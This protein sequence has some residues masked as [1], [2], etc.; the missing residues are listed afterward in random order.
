MPFF[1]ARPSAVFGVRSKRGILP[2]LTRQ[3]I[4]T[5]YVAA[6]Y[7]DSSP[8]R[9][10]NSFDMSTDTCT[11]R[12]DLLQTAS[13]Y[14][15]GMHGRNN[16]FILGADGMGD[17]TTV[18]SFN[19]RNNTTYTKPAGLVLNWAVGSSGTVMSQNDDGDYLK[20][21]NWTGAGGTTQ[22]HTFN[23]V[24]EATTTALNT[25]WGGAGTS[26][27]L[28]DELYGYIWDE[29]NARTL[30]IQYATDGLT[31]A[32]WVA[33]FHGQQKGLSAKTGRGYAGNEGTYNGGNN[34]RISNFAT[35]T[36]IGTVAKPIQDSG[37]ENYVTGQD[38]GY[39]LGMYGAPGPT[40]NNRSFRFNYSTQS[41]SE[42]GASGQP[43]GGIAAAGRSSGIGMWRD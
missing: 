36:N 41:G 8:W 38:R 3:I 5:G 1:S 27:Q 40:Q 9:N 24:T 31:N 34:F 26:N 12:G 11:N 4:T 32:A 30:K 37:E 22:L 39:M 23:L 43:S 14:S 20:A 13:A 19:M 18:A 21:W 35:Q 7:K 16:G 33:G 10:V 2:F 17:G 28:M 25:S 6:G 29:S 42:L 15:G